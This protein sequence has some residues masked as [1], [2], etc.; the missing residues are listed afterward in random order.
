MRFI[1][2]ELALALVRLAKRFWPVQYGADVM[3]GEH[4]NEAI[5]SAEVCAP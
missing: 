5:G 3:F 1:R 2:Q 4:I